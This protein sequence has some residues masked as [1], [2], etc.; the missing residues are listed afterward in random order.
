MTIGSTVGAQGSAQVLKAAT[1]HRRAACRYN[2]RITADQMFAR[3][4]G[5]VAKLDCWSW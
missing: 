4:I 1:P 3:M 2:Q 5:A